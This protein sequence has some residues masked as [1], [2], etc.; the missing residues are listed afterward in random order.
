MPR[1]APALECTAEDAA[2]LVAISKSHTEEARTVE[3]A[4]IVLAC[5]TGKQNQQVARDLGVSVPT[6]SK[7]R[8][9]FA[10]WGLRGLLDLNEFALVRSGH[11]NVLAVRR[12]LWRLGS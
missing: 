11:L 10:F 4:R 5:L 3:R 1:H 2:R 8:Q 6:V 12:G 9:R 7:W